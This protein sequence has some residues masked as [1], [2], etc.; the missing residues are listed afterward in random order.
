MKILLKI[1]RPLIMG[2]MIL[3]LYLM[4]TSVL[5]ALE[6]GGIKPDLL[7]ILTSG[8]GIIRGRKEGMLVGFASGLLLDIQ[9]G[10]LLGFYALIY[11]LIG[12]LNGY[13]RHVFFNEELKLPLILI[14]CSEFG[15]GMLVY[16]LQF[17]L[18]AL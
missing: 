12:Y 11:V 1:R 4:Q 9:I 14:G 18:N 13:A 2:L 8:I 17:F 16:I 5:P 15:Y 6:L 10:S 3:V 7:V